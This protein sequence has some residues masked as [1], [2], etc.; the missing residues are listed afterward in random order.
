M[1]IGDEKIREVAEKVL[2]R[3]NDDNEL[4]E[5]DEVF[6]IV[7]VHYGA[8]DLDEDAEVGELFYRCSSARQHVQFGLLEQARRAVEE[9]LRNEN[10]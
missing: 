1:I 2:D 5:V 8:A 7:A 10:D 4:I 3:L 9:V 6:L